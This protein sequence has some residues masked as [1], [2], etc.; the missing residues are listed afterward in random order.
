MPLSLTYSTGG[1]AADGVTPLGTPNEHDLQVDGS[2][3]ANFGNFEVPEPAAG[4]M[5]VGVLG[6]GAQM[7]NPVTSGFNFHVC[8][9][10]FIRRHGEPITLIQG[11]VDVVE[12]AFTNDMADTDVWVEL[13]DTG[14]L[15]V[16]V[17][18]TADVLVDD[19]PTPQTLYVRFKQLAG[20]IWFTRDPNA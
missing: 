16:M 2:G 8:Y 17:Q 13:V 14:H 6:F 18:G 11:A 5:T 9:Q 12:P 1:F 15:R 4:Q 20:D 19:V 3:A 7:V 10:R